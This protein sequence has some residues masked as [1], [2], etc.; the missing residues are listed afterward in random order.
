MAFFH[1]MISIGMPAILRARAST[2]VSFLL[3]AGARRRKGRC[4]E[5][6]LGAK[7]LFYGIRRL[8]HREPDPLDPTACA[9]FFA[10]FSYPRE[11][12]PEGGG[13]LLL[14]F[15]LTPV[16]LAPVKSGAPWVRDSED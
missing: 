13:R 9:D 8:R 16:A 4:G 6:C 15:Y 2:M 1:E 7:R 12:P 11:R 14:L 10:L 3:H 5:H